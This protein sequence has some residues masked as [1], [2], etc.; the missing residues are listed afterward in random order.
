MEK[1]MTIRE[2]LIQEGR[3]HE[4]IEH[5]DGLLHVATDT[6][7]PF[8]ISNPQLCLCERKVFYSVSHQG[9]HGYFT[10]GF[11]RAEENS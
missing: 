10:I 7:I 6:V 8:Q 3:I 2:Q 4:F 11:E 1:N 9:L 5:P